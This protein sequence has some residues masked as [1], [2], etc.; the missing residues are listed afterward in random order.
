MC[1]ILL[2]VLFVCFSD[3]QSIPGGKKK[4][5]QNQVQNQ[6]QNNIWPWFCLQI[7]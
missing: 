6:V 5:V 1:V 4:K 7:I 2:I 3:G